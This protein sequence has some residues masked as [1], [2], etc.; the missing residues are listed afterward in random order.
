MAN[1]EERYCNH[2]K[3]ET[4]FFQ[5]FDL[6]WYCDECNQIFGSYPIMEDEQIKQE[7][8]DYELEYGEAV[9]CKTCGNF[10]LLRDVVDD[11]VCPYC[12]DDLE[13]ELYEKGYEYSE[14]EERYIKQF[15]SEEW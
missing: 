2:C 1:V 4:M 12:T 13:T 10:V 8:E 6:L 15:D 3:R 5:G 7:L 11:G 9:Y 14:E